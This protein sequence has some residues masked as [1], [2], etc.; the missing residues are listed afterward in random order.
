[1]SHQLMNDPQAHLEAHKPPSGNA[2]S[3]PVVVHGM[4]FRCRT[5]LTVAD[6]MALPAAFFALNELAA[7]AVLFRLLALAENGLAFIRDGDDEW[8]NGLD[9]VAIHVGMKRAGV[10]GMILDQLRPSADEDA[11]PPG[12]RQASN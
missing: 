10:L 2:G 4:A 8:Y 7:N 11:A 3:V 6:V 5:R 1:M 9:A 12:K